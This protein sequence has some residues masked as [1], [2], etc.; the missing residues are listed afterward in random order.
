MTDNVPLWGFLSIFL[1]HGQCICDKLGHCQPYTFYMAL[2]GGSNSDST[3]MC[4]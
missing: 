1:L 4:S 2:H 3:F